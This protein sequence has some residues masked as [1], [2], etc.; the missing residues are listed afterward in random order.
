[1][2]HPCDRLYCVQ[3]TERA[4]KRIFDNFC[5][6]LATLELFCQQGLAFETWTESLRQRGIVS[7]P[8]PQNFCGGSMTLLARRYRS[9]EAMI[10]ASFP[11]L[12][13]CLK[14]W[15][16]YQPYVPP[17]GLKRALTSYIA[18]FHHSFPKLRK[19]NLTAISTVTSHFMNFVV[20][21]F[22]VLFS[23]TNHDR[24]L[25]RKQPMCPQIETLILTCCA[26]LQ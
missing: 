26:A 21:F 2:E 22:P 18:L 24:N 12:Q 3:A 23:E 15:G 1:V 16:L 20:C 13:E 7:M 5:N 6:V 4:H 8:L 14:D 25:C 9:M 17:A 10:E 11:R 19:Y